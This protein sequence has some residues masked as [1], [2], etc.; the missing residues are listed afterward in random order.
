MSIMS[1]YIVLHYK[2]LLWGLVEWNRQKGKL[3]ILLIK[4]NKGELSTDILESTYRI[5]TY[6]S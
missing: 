1:I 4:K 5:S 6:S 2:E 3:L